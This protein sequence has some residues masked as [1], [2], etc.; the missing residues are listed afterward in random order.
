MNKKEIGLDH[1]QIQ[2]QV[3]S[4]LNLCKKQS[5]DVF[6][7]TFKGTHISFYSPVFERMHIH[8]TF[9]DANLIS[10]TGVLG[11]FFRSLKKPA[12]VV[13]VLF[14]IV[15]WYFLS[16]FIFAVEIHGENTVCKKAIQDAVRSLGYNIPFSVDEVQIKKELKSYL[17]D[18]VA[19][20]E[21][22]K[23]GSRLHITYT[24]KQQAQMKQITRKQLY[25]LKD[26]LIA[27]FDIK[28]GEKKVKVNQIVH[29]GDLLV[30]NSLNDS[31]GKVQELDVE[32][33][34]FAYTWKDVTVYAKPQDIKAFSYFE[35]LM[36]ARRE[37]TKDFHKDDKIITEN[38]LQFTKEVGKIKMVI[39]YTMLQDITSP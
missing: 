31:K 29:K 26:G 23:Q 3:N 34:V 7:C 10:T 27:K 6:D 19:W 33:K 30:A 35:M 15:L 13:S 11:Y 37:V 12:F 14:S 21:V 18:K 38:I 4:F 22:E 20:L 28:H 9:P 24:P 32:G 25:A 39:H 16:H 36:E 17:S 8:H 2:A 1:W 5:I